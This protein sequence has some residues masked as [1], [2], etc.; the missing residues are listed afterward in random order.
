[1]C[2]ASVGTDTGGSI[3]IPS[4]LCGVVGLKPTFGLVSVEGIVPLALSLDHAGPIARSAED[5][6]IVLEAI[7]GAYPQ[8]AMRPDYRRL[9]H[10]VPKPIRLGLPAHYFFDRIDGEVRELIDSAARV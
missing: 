9:E 2:F 8:G 4:A 5:A 10:H 6:C 1:M 7:A 3:R